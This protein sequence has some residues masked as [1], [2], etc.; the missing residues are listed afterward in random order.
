MKK[1]VI[2]KKNAFAPPKSYV[3]P[4]FRLTTYI[5]TYLFIVL[6]SAC[7][8]SRYQYLR[9][10]EDLTRYIVKIPSPTNN[11]NTNKQKAKAPRSNISTKLICDDIMHYAPDSLHY[12]HTPIRYIK[13][14][15][16]IIN[17][18]DSSRNFNGEEG[19]LFIKKVLEIAN[20]KLND[21][22]KMNL[23][24]G[25]HTPVLKPRFQWQL[26]GMKD[27]PTDDGIYYHY[28]DSLFWI[29]K[30][31]PNSFHSRD[32]C[33]KYGIQ[34]DSVINVF[35]VEHHPDSCKSKTYK[36]SNDGIG[37]SDCVKVIGA[38]Q[39]YTNSSANSQKEGFEFT[40]ISFANLLNHEL[41][42]SLGLAHTW[43]GSDGCDDT[44]QNNNCWHYLEGVSECLTEVSNNIMDYNAFRNALTPCQ[45]GKVQ[46]NLAKPNSRQRPYLRQDWCSYNKQETIYIGNGDAITWNST[47]ELNGDLV[48]QNGGSLTILCA[49]SMPPDSRILVEKGGILVLDGCK[50]G[51]HCAM[52]RAWQGIILQGVGKKK[53]KK[54]LFVHNN[55]TLNTFKN[56][57]IH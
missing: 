16:H 56:K 20:A 2:S 25:N 21:N 26:V 13:I 31:G 36:S 7:S 53:S 22:Q 34:S 43:I 19:R 4:K 51:Q 39:T 18:Q 11:K 37:Y 15:V 35:F 30:K 23:P 45:I 6:F 32:I 33:K 50:I 10:S 42:H 49:L 17:S 8:S 14:N 52:P 48:V 28:N 40:T 27:N 44:P 47:K 55:A 57:Q 3:W 5:I 29:N 38:Y 24:I 9:S 12:E 1:I 46:C 41:G 54:Q